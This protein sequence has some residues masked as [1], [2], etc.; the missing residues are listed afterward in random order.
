MSLL[1]G[2]AR[3]EGAGACVR[4]YLDWN[5]TA[6]P[7]PGVQEA[8]DAA[9]REAWGNPSSVHAIGRRARACVEDAREAVARVSGEQ[10]EVPAKPIPVKAGG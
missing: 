3:T 4:V 2:G 1:G 6:Q 8:M 9:H 5:A 7:L 10:I